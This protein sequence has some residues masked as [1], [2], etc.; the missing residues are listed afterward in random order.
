MD[1]SRREVEQRGR[2]LAP[3]DESEAIEIQPAGAGQLLAQIAE[4]LFQQYPSRS[5]LGATLMIT[6]SFLYNAIFFTYALVLTNFYD[7]DSRHAPLL[8]LPVRDR[9]PR[10]ARCCSAT[11]STRSAGAR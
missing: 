8:L 1:R 11:S 7:V 5:I 4:V 6:Q 10:S 3:V 9:Q 2:Q